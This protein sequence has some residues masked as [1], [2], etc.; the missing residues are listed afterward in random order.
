MTHEPILQATDVEHSYGT[1]PVLEGVR[2]EI[3]A[4]A[5]TALL[6]PNGSGKSTLIR[7]IV[8]LNRPDEGTVSY[9]GPD[10]C[11]TIGYLP[12]RPSFRSGQ[13]VLDT[14]TFYASLVGESRSAAMDSLERVGLAEAADR[15]AAALSGGMTR[16]VGI[17]QALLGD[18][19]VIVLDEPAS[20]LDPEMSVHI[21]D[22]LEELTAD[23]TAVLLSSH[24]LALVERTADE[25]A[26]LDD[27]QIVESGPTAA[28]TANLEV[29]TL[30]DVFKTAI[31][32]EPGTVRVK[33]GLYG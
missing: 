1:V 5:I 31:G 2:L 24:D 21:F 33:E 15:D 17:A 29:D 14:L 10:R 30:L 28:V 13:S 27:G 20:G 7:T 19:P 26:L 11:R 23:G 32:G 3:D 18:P 12:Q 25:I 22:V 16:L 8:G 6:G 4:G 9:N